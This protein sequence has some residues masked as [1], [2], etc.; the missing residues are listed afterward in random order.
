MRFDTFQLDVSKKTASMTKE[1]ISILLGSLYIA[2]LAQIEIPL[3]PVPITMHT[4]AILSLP[5]FQ[6]SRKSMFSVLLYLAE[7]TIGLPVFP[8]GWSDPFWI[9]A[10]TAGYFLSFP[11]SAYIVGTSIESREV[12][13]GKMTMRLLCAQA[14]IYFIG[15][16][17]LSVYVGLEPALTFGLYPFILID[18]I[19]LLAAFSIKMSFLSFAGNK[20]EFY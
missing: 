9:T 2:L 17:W 7:A 4:F 14:S 18:S 8:N 6:G 10:P 20:H 15:I 3:S 5:L 16:S 1:I 13:V 12:S 11:L 19:K